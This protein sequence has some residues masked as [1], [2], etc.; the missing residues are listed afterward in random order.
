MIDRTVTAHDDAVA[1]AREV[2]KAVKDEKRR[3]DLIA[4]WD[5]GSV[6]G[7]GTMQALKAEVAKSVPAWF[8]KNPFLGS[9]PE[10]GGH[11]PP[12]V[13]EVED[14]DCVR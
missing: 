10:V 1:I 14:D 6:K 7:F 2:G 8:F 13:S 11:S 9:A 5:G 3:F 12:K 4:G